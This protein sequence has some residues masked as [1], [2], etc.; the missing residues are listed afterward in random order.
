MLRP[1]A[2]AC[3]TFASTVTPR[4]SRAVRMISFFFSWRKFHDHAIP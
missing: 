1:C 4:V 2:L 3:E